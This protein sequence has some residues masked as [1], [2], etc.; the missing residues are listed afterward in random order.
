LIGYEYKTTPRKHQESDCSLF[1]DREYFAHL[2]EPGC[3]KSKIIVDTAAHLFE[4]DKIDCVIVIAPNGVHRKWITKEVSAHLPDRIPREAHFWESRYGKK[5]RDTIKNILLEKSV[6]MKWFAMGFDS[7]YRRS[8]FELLLNILQSKRCMLVLDESTY[9]KNP[10]ARR[11]KALHQLAEF[12]L[13][14]R[15]LS[16]SPIANSPMDL[17]AQYHFLSPLA[18]KQ[19]SFV[20]FRRRY[21]DVTQVNYGGGRPVP[22]ILGY[23]NQ[24]DLNE[25][26]MACSSRYLKKDCLDLPDKIYT[27]EWVTLSAAQSKA[28]KEMKNE[29]YTEYLGQESTAA[30]PI[31]KFL[32]L[33]QIIGGFIKLDVEK[34]V[35]K[36]EGENPK[37]KRML[38]LIDQMDPSSS[39]IIW[40]RFKAELKMIK[41]A[42]GDQARIYDGGTSSED[43]SEILKQFENKDIRFFVGNPAAGGIGIDLVAAEYVIYFSNDFSSLNRIQSE[44]R[45]HRIGQKK[46][47]TYIDL[48]AEGT[49]DVTIINA[50][51]NKQDVANKVLMEGIYGE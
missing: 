30:L 14:R 1:W 26:I 46:N 18:L 2:H 10:R 25:K 50:L 35:T 39:V 8:Q 17:W 13:F 3:G 15:I 51:E 11:T 37:L 36:I 6:D 27:K 19:R 20:S 34:D 40:G 43:K 49:V 4:I 45:A 24:D 28:Y 7:V 9:I 23:K 31:V 48:L 5:K 44:D 38:E 29:L 47:V 21:A 12:A 42:L 22:M 41:E 32:R 16:G 33:Q